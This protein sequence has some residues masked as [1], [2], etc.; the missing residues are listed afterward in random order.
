MVMIMNKSGVTI[1]ELLISVSMISVVIL[2]LVKVMFSLNNINNDE[3]YASQDEIKRTEIIKNIE[4]DFLKLKL[5]GLTITDNENTTLSFSFENGFKNL[6]M[7]KDKI[8]YDKETFS[9]NSKNATYSLCPEYSYHELENDY[10]LIKISIPVLIDGKNT[11]INDDL[12]FSYIGL[13][14]DVTNFIESF[15]CLKK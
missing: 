6:K 12:I 8:I 3:T 4:N 2:L 15:N 9:L 10:Y 1:I 5:N 11:T 7:Y 14:N 13:K